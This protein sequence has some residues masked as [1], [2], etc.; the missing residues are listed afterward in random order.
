MSGKDEICVVSQCI[1]Y[2]QP[3]FWLWLG[4]ELHQGLLGSG[5]MTLFF[6]GCTSSWL[7]RLQSLSD[8]YCQST[9]LCVC[10]CV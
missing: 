8:L 4:Y 6:I 2:V 1:C 9:C 5:E 3:V 10:D 7:E